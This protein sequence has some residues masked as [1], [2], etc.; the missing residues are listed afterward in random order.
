MNLS[1]DELITQFF[2]FSEDEQQEVCDL[3]ESTFQERERKKNL[4]ATPKE[5]QS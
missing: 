2:M 1:T 5:E 3:I 4:I